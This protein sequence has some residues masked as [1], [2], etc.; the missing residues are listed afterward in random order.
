MTEENYQ[1]RKNNNRNNDSSLTTGI[2][3]I[4]LGVLFLISRYFPAID[5]RDL[6]PFILI[7]VGIL[8]IYRGKQNNK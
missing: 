1:P 5:F 6:W 3:L 2:I 4:T 8:I 7:V